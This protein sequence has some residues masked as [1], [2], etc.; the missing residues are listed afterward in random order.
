MISNSDEQKDALIKE[1]N[2]KDESDMEQWRK[3]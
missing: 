1:L 3:S 2:I